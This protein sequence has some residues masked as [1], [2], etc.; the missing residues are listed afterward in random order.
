MRFGSSNV[1][2]MYFVV[3]VCDKYKKLFHVNWHVD[4]IFV[5][6]WSETI[7]EYE[8]RQCFGII[9]DGNVHCECCSKL[10]MTCTGEL[11]AF[12][13][14]L[15]TEIL[16]IFLWCK[17][18]MI[19]ERMV[20][21][22]AIGLRYSFRCGDFIVVMIVYSLSLCVILT[23]HMIDDGPKNSALSCG[24]GEFITIFIDLF[25]CWDTQNLLT[26][27]LVRGPVLS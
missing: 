9:H 14:P 27:V 13:Y 23:V 6:W 26:Q 1:C 3:Y 10:W 7:W 12:R 24:A 20:H 4:F 22:A 11:T 17:W 15:A 8:N 25:V 2:K 18:E 5:C 16:L 19:A 21:H